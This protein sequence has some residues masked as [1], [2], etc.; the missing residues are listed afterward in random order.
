M[1]P[2]TAIPRAGK[3]KSGLNQRRA[4]PPA[5]E[6]AAGASVA[7]LGLAQW[8][9]AMVEHVRMVS[10]SIEGRLVSGQEILELLAKVLR[11]HTMCRRRKIDQVVIWLKEQQNRDACCAG[12]AR[13]RGGA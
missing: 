8:N 4:K 9:R 1:S 5:P 2:I 10:S 12:G 3:K 13:G 7:K 6:P 11:I